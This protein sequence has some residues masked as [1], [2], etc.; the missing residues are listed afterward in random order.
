MLKKAI[1]DRRDPYLAL[2]EYRNTPI[3]AEIGSPAELMFGRKIRGLLPHKQIFSNKKNEEIRNK[4]IERQNIQKAYYDR[5]VVNPKP[6]KSNDDVYVQK[7]NNIKERGIVV[8]ECERPRS[9]AVQLESGNVVERNRKHLYKFKLKS[10]FKVQKTFSELTES[11]DTAKETN[12]TENNNTEKIMEK[13]GDTEK[14]LE[15]QG[16][17]V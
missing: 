2:L 16:E 8:E 4:L 10:K 1:Y 13:Q 11:E 9:Y 5:G 12:V 17:R 7:S 3:T 14:V 15:K 6:L